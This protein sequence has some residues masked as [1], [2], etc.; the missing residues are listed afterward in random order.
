MASSAIISFGEGVR[1]DAGMAESAQNGHPMS[2]LVVG[3]LCREKNNK[4]DAIQWLERAA[5]AGLSD[6]MYYLACLYSELNNWDAAIQWHE[7]TG[8]KRSM[9]ALGEIYEYE[10]KDMAKAAHWYQK[11]ASHK[12]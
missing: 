7:K 11:A 1:I 5:T 10:K 6:G 9:Q 2:M 12:M 3:L 4:T 8:W